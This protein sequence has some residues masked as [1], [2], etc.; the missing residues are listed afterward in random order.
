MEKPSLKLQELEPKPEDPWGD[1]K[2]GRKEIAN[3]LTNVLRDEPG[4]LVVALNGEWGTGKTFLLKRWQLK[5]KSDGYKAIYF[6]AWED[7]FMGDPLVAIIGQLWE[8]LKGTDFEEILK[9]VKEVAKPL[10]AKTVFNT[11]RVMSKGYVDI[12]AKD[13]KSA[14]E[15]AVDDYATQGCQRRDL[16]K[17]L[18]HLANEVRKDTEH[19]LV[20]IIDELDR[21]RPTFAIETL[22]RVKHI[23]D[24]ENMVFAL[25]V[26]QRQLES[27]IRAVYGD[28]EAEGYL[29]RFIDIS[30][31]LPKAE[32][33]AFCD[34]VIARHGIQP[35]VQGLCKNANREQLLEDLG[36]FYLQFPELCKA[37]DLPLRDIEHAMRLFILA[38]RNLSGSHPLFTEILEVLIILRI[39]DI[40]LYERYSQGLCL[41][42]EVASRIL[43]NGEGETVD[44]CYHFDRIEAAIYLSDLE[45]NE[46]P[47]FEQLEKKKNKEELTKPGLL[48]N[49]VLRKSM[50]QL[51]E[52]M[53]I[54][55]IIAEGIYRGQTVIKERMS[56]LIEKIE[57]AR[58]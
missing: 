4:P 18:Q 32:V 8:S 38:V 31:T 21:C 12:D 34:H 58:P 48:S 5:L 14:A 7:D 9:S 36:V 15:N 37:L 10:I 47:I 39:A 57:L 22:E 43:G 13:L 41:P 2:L 42:A 52:F 20:F 29:R 24:I 3:A 49:R 19:P 17:R 46:D 30:F 56:R 28:I 40:R 53:T 11:A 6:N 54:Y 27:S 45:T 50:V 35:F 26:E 44:R 1:D 25:G 51:D 55:R 23:F 16:R 33:K